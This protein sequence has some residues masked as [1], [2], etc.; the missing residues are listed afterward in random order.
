MYRKIKATSMTVG[1]QYLVSFYD[2][3]EVKHN[4]TLLNKPEVPIGLMTESHLYRI[5]LDC[6]EI[7]VFNRNTSPPHFLE[8]RRPGKRGM[9]NVRA[10][11]FE[12]KEAA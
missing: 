5:S 10:S 9:V 6:G 7:V 8:T 4:C 1:R 12:I 11:F 3:K 2:D